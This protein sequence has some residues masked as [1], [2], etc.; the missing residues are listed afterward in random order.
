MLVWIMETEVVKH[1]VD[2][3]DEDE[4]EDSMSEL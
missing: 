2:G 4:D 1:D 3:E